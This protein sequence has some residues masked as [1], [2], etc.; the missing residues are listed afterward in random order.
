MYYMMTHIVLALLAVCCTLSSQTIQTS[1]S[2][3]LI[4]LGCI[5]I[6]ISITDY[7]SC[8]QKVYKVLNVRDCHHCQYDLTLV[9]VY[10]L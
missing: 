10:N 5:I 2:L 3:L 8:P 4:G 6:I 9:S 7:H 1:V